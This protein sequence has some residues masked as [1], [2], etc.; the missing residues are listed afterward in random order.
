MIAYIPS[1][2]NGKIVHRSVVVDDKTQMA[3]LPGARMSKDPRVISAISAVFEE[4]A[5]QL[6]YAIWADTYDLFDPS[7]KD[8]EAD[9]EWSFARV[10]PISKWAFHASGLWLR[11]SRVFVDVTIGESTISGHTDRL[12]Q[13]DLSDIPQVQVCLRHCAPALFDQ[14]VSVYQVHSGDFIDI[15]SADHVSTLESI[16]GCASDPRDVLIPIA[17]L[18]CLESKLCDADVCRFDILTSPTR[19]GMGDDEYL[20]MMCNWVR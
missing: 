6:A 9:F 19:K 13:L 11:W 4:S 14:N 16:L 3:Y 18:S 7:T 15:L 12:I 1:Y 17:R 10:E 8:I 5:S 2:Y 20:E